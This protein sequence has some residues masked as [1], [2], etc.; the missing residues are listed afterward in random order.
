MSTYTRIGA[1]VDLNAVDA[2]L[3][4]I[5]SGLSEKTKVTAVVKTD[6]YGHGA[7]AIA[8]YIEKREV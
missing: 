7:C 8:Q 1:F 2:N 3:D 6:A 4:A 5:K